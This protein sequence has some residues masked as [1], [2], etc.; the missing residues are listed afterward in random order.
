[1]KLLVI[2]AA[3]AALAIAGCDSKEGGTAPEGAQGADL[4]VPADYEEEAEKS[5]TSAN[6]KDELGALEKE[7]EAP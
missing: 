6:Y 7:V 5:I 4:P 3:T 2:L 1:V